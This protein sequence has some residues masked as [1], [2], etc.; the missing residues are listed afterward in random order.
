MKWLLLEEVS[1]LS[2]GV[3]EYIDHKR[4]GLGLEGPEELGDLG[5]VI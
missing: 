3:E 2:L 5:E 1:S 4:V